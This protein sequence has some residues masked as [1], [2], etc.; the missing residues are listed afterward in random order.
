MLS[1]TLH[2][3]ALFIASVILLLAN[4]KS[5]SIFNTS[6]STRCKTDCI[7]EDF[8]FCPSADG[9]SGTCCDSKADC[10]AV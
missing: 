2:K 1:R 7:D 10:S 9:K 6:L 4:V 5:E 3:I 8:Y